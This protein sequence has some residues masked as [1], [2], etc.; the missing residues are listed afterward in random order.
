MSA[1][2]DDGVMHPIARRLRFILAPGF[3]RVLM[4]LFGAVFFAL[5]AVDLVHHRH[6]L[7]SWEGFAGFHAWFGFLAF[8]FVVIMGWPLGRLLSRPENYYAEDDEAGEESG[9]ADDA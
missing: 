3:G 6:E 8:S 5:A 4:Y 9:E 2:F 1:G 7:F